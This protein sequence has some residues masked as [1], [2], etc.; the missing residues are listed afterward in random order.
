M[1]DKKTFKPCDLVIF[2]ALGD[3]SRRKLIISLYRLENA[4]LIESDTR[5]I[6][7]D[8][9]PNENS[10]FIEIAHKSLQAFLNDKLDDD[11]WQRFSARLSYLKIDLTQLDQYKQLKTVTDAKSRMLVNYFA[12][13]P[14]LFKSICQ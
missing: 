2:G 3:L 8:R 6:G 9:H 11:V 13:S 10:Q 14:F 1:K 7:V 12:V 4:N 5:I